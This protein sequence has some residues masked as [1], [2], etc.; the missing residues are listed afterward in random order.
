MDVVLV[1]KKFAPFVLV[2]HDGDAIFYDIVFCFYGV[3]RKEEGV[4]RCREGRKSNKGR[5]GA[6]PC[7]FGMYFNI[8]F[9]TG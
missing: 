5:K 3:K 7:S 8:C 9:W 1:R 4:R 2:G 6:P